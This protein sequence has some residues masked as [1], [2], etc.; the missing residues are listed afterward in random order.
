MPHSSPS[1]LSWK[2]YA[3]YA[4]VAL[5]GLVVM[6]LPFAADWNQIRHGWNDFPAF[7]IGAEIVGSGDLYDANAFV[8]EQNRLLGR[9]NQNIIYTRLPFVAVLEAPMRF[10]PYGVAYALWQVLSLAA[11]A[12]FA[13]M[14]PARRPLAFVICCWFPPVAATL[15]NGQD[16]TYLLLWMVAAIWLERAGRDYG[17]GAALVIAAATK[18]HLFLLVPVAILAKRKWKVGAGF[19]IGGVVILLICFLAAGLRWPAEFLARLQDPAVHPQIGSS[20]V[21]ASLAAVLHGPE[22]WTVAMLIAIAVGV[23]IF[24]LARTQDFATTIAVAVA[25]GLV[26]GFHVYAQ[27]YLLALPLLL[28]LVTRML[29]RKERTATVAA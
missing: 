16:V 8:A 7:Y 1:R 26:V 9:N 24:R 10:L 17:A 12:L 14:W 11:L 5:T 25:A 29:E 3:L 4:L 28:L 27:D 18:P 19:A 15:A 23:L 6:S 22:F 13:V 2:G 20:S 21:L